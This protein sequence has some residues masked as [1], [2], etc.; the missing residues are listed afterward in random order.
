MDVSAA[1]QRESEVVNLLD[2]VDVLTR[3]QQWDAA[4]KEMNDNYRRYQDGA[5]VVLTHARLREAR[6]EYGLAGD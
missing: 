4:L 2:R 1:T 3:R 5:R 6:G